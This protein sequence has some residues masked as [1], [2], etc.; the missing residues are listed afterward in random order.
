MIPSTISKR[1]GRFSKPSKYSSNRTASTATSS[2]TTQSVNLID[3]IVLPEEDTAVPLDIWNT[4]ICAIQTLERNPREFDI[5]RKC[6]ICGETGHAF[7]DCPAL[8]N[9]QSLKD[10]RVA[11]GQFLG[12]LRFLEQKE[13]EARQKRISQL[14]ATLILSMRKLKRPIRIF[15]WAENKFTFLQPSCVIRRLDSRGR[16]L[17]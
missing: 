12:K 1:L 4:Y 5:S 17:P 14:M 16:R 15:S 7:A 8:N 6:L 3:S 9:A 10:H 2:I 11:I 13:V